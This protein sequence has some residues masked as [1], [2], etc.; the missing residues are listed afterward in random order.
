MSTSNPTNLPSLESTLL[1]EIKPEVKPEVKSTT[2]PEI[3]PF[4]VN[5]ARAKIVAIRKHLKQ[6]EGQEGHNPHIWNRNNL[7][8]VESEL[9]STDVA[10]KAKALAAIQAL[11]AE[12]TPTVTVKAVSHIG[13]YNPKG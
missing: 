13:V 6:F 3:K 12:P 2:T 1:P 8:K 4:T 11:P 7:L 10:T 9:D 5:Q